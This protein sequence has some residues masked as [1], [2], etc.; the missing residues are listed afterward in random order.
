MTDEKAIRELIDTTKGADERE[1]L[2]IIDKSLESRPL[3]LAESAALLN[4][5][6]GALIARIE[7][8][9]R[10]VKEKIYGRRM[11]LFAPMYISNYCV[12]DC[13]YCG[14]KY[15]NKSIP[16]RNLTLGEI[17]E[18]TLEILKSGHKRILI[19]SGEDNKK[20]DVDFLVKAIETVYGVEYRGNKI[21]RVNVNI[22]PCEAGGLKKLK[23]AGIGTYQLFQETFHRETYSSLHPSGPKK[24]YDKRLAIFEKCFEAGVDDV[25]IGVLY[26]LYDY[27]FETLSMLSF[28]SY[29]DGKYGVGPHT[30]SVPR[31]EPAEGCDNS[32]I[33]RYPVP[34]DEFKKLIAVLRLSVPYTG[35]ILS[36]REKP[37][38]RDELVK[39]G[40]SQ[41]SAG[42]R[43]EP[44]GYGAPGKATGQFV[45][46]DERSLQEVISQLVD[47]GFI[48]SFCTS[49]Y[50]SERT[51]AA[52]MEMS[53]S[54]HIHD[55]C[56]TN[57]LLT[58]HE[59]LLDFAPAEL[60]DRGERLIARM[61]NEVL[62][63]KQSD[64]F[65]KLYTELT[66]GKRDVFV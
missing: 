4:C 1:I 44:G 56:D 18:E 7:S 39:V 38:F 21:R 50:R 34:D 14:F 29:L 6:D 58:F 40:V 55:F 66:S 43:T 33:A 20:C 45:V 2:R 42:S 25:G 23:A 26:G 19:V 10:A 8:A 65:I 52:F 16:R 3:E 41:L 64:I 35:I 28:A 47:S 31:I 37:E 49:C 36:T 63:R 48:P 11:V 24:D 22:A 15:S 9:A 30:I 53:K 17:A 13:A 27:K 5:D 57:A 51:G 12:N 46:S 62:D 54:S 61:K 32:S 60:A 59:Y